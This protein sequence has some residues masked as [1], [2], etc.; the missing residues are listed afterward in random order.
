M[1]QADL[2]QTPK[3]YG[4]CPG[5]LRPMMSGDGLVV[6]VRPPL[7]R[8]TPDQARGLADLSQRCGSG[9]LD[10]SARANLQLRGI[11]DTAYDAL[12]DGLRHLEL[13]DEDAA[14]EARRN[15]AITPFWQPG[16]DSHRIASALAAALSA[17]DDLVLPGKFG[18]VVDC[19]PTPVLRDTAADIRIERCD[20]GVMLRADGAD[21]GL[22]LTAETVAQE[23]IALAR[24]F[25]DQGGAPEGRGRMRQL[26]ARRALPA[27]HVA[28]VLNAPRAA[29]PQP[30]P[31]ESGVLVALEFGQMPAAT[32]AALADHGALRLTPWRMLL[33]EDDSDAAHH[34][35][36]THTAPTLAAPTQSDLALEGLILEGR[37]PRLR[38][39]ACTGAPNCHQA[40]STTRNLARDLAAY[41][42]AGRHLHVSGCAKGCAHPRATDYVLTATDPD[43]FDLIRNGTAADQPLH[44]S[45]SARALRAAPDFLTEGN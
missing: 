12:I 19:G 29:T 24:W 2:S 33:I 27:S 37:D 1:T 5:A 31:T 42:P 17:A 22:A 20:T 39:T 32:L 9:L 40:R 15:I 35:A 13:L 43:V 23:A 36:P 30:G 44:T 21:H 34:T 6:R 10:V 26:I 11:R 8:L 7:G 16:D 25:L 3:V 28:P 18:F 41:V 14:A 4:W 45:L 38:V